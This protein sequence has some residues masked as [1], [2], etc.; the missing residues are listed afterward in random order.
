MGVSSLPY[1]VEN[2][3][4]HGMDPETPAVMV[5]QG[6]TSAQRRVLSTL[7]GLPSAIEAAGLE[8]PA[9]FAIGPTVEH[10][11]TLDWI[12]NL[13]LA[14][15]RLLVPIA[16]LRLGKF[17]EEYGAEVLLTPLPLTPAARVA[18]GALPLTGCV[19]GTAA[20]VD[21]LDTERREQGWG[22]TVV[23]WCVGPEAANRAQELNW[24]DLRPLAEDVDD[25]GLMEQLRIDLPRNPNR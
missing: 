3:L 22:D 11:E 24:P 19:V 2:L 14:G 4:R 7:S 10:A 20:D 25:I 17:L 1:V 8:P 18:V 9:L 15:H 13:P 16:Q 6:T 23:A 12:S 21:L 5:E